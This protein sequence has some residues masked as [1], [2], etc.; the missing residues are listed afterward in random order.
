MNAISENCELDEKLF[1]AIKSIDLNKII[2]KLCDSVHGRGWTYERAL[3]AADAYTKFLYLTE[4]H[5]DSAIV[6]TKDIDEVWHAHILD[7]R[8]YIRDCNRVFG[9]YVHHNPFFGF[10]GATAEDCLESSFRSTQ[11][12]FRL[13][14]NQEY[15]ANQS[16]CSRPVCAR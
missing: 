13:T 6:P 10:G 8:S 14:F 12:L 7:T 9:R 3:A 2:E 16:V 11:E 15:Q 4:K 1:K 5:I